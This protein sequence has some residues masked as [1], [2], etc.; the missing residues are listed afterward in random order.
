MYITFKKNYYVVGNAEFARSWN[1]LKLSPIISINESINQQ[2]VLRMAHSPL[3]NAR[4]ALK[5]V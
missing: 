2:G 1:T 3:K 4:E 5:K